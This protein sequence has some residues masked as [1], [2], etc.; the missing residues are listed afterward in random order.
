MELNYQVEVQDHIHSQLQSQERDNLLK[1]QCGSQNFD[2][3]QVQIGMMKLKLSF[4]N[5][6]ILDLDR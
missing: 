2:F 5:N 6:M 3:G 1:C 4:Q